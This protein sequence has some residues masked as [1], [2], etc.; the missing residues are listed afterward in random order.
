VTFEYISSL[1]FSEI[2]MIYTLSYAIL[3]EIA[4]HS[5]LD[6]DK[7]VEDNVL[8]RGNEGA[9]PME[10]I[11]ADSPLML[12]IS[13]VERD[14]GLSK[15]VL[16]VWERRYNFPQPLRDGN[17]ERVYPS[18]QVNQLRMIRRLMDVGH[19]PG[20][21]LAMTQDELA[22]LDKHRNTSHRSV[23]VAEPL[24]QIMLLLRNHDAHG[25][26]TAL[27]QLLA[28]Q[29][30]QRF[31]IETV[32]ALNRIIG[33]RWSTGDLDIYVEHFYTECIRSVMY[34]AIAT[35]PRNQHEPRVLLST[36]ANEE[37]S[38]GLLLVE[39]LLCSEGA[40]TISLGVDLSTSEIS[41]AVDA[42]KPNIICLSFSPAYPI[43]QAIT[44]LATLRARIPD[45]TEIWVGGALSRR[46]R[47]EA[48]GFETMIELSEVITA[49][50]TW[51]TSRI[52][53]TEAAAVVEELSANL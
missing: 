42:F 17:D 2:A 46:L 32:S 52:A 3:I 11:E 49:M 20:K 15:D 16:R 30:I 37:H 18:I 45:D 23:P 1:H 5:K 13:A 25:V 24:R 29:G 41:K 28:K 35:M 31:A 8:P 38:L 19:R 6:Q 47:R 43:K 4:A 14:T 7:I 27:S 10:T 12:T 50:R 51:R 36:L 26:R 48:T 39:S 21:L 44:G 9:K 22:D 34:S 33:E 40:T 53:S